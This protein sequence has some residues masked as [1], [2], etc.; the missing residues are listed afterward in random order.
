MKVMHVELGRQLYGGALQVAYLLQGLRERGVENH[1]VCTDGSE[2][3]DCCHRNAVVHEVTAG[4]DLDLRFPIALRRLIRS[5]KPD[6]LHVHSRRGADFWG[7]L[8][9]SQCRV[10]AIVTRRVDNP[11]PGWWA[12]WK[13]SRF[14]KVVTISE[15]I[16]HVLLR[17]GVPPESLCCVRSAIDATPYQHEGDMDWF[18]KEFDFSPQDRTIAVIAQLIPRKGHRYL[19]QALPKVLVNHPD[20]K[21]LFLGKG[22]SRADLER[23]VKE[24]AL[25]EIVVFA[26][27]RT[28]LER[29]LPCLDLVV[30]PALMEGLGVS[31]VQAAAAGVPIIASAAGGIPEVVRDGVNGVLVEPADTACLEAA[32]NLL[33][34]DS[35][36]L[37]TLGEGGRRLVAEEFGVDQMVEGNVAVYEKLLA[38]S[39][40]EGR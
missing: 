10:P 14:S 9:A 36:K 19:L 16:R 25:E 31:L 30:H 7:G 8:V 12:R 24:L 40:R 20:L 17:E 15:G 18:R 29:L 21:V 32:I 5:V 22:G 34:A 6:I 26:G 11:E 4:G 35:L 27:F 23:L 37:K 38:L 28:D 2:I 3:A 1:L 33:L 13:Y 39:G